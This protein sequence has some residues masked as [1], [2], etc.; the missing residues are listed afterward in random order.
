[1]SY[2]RVLVPLNG[3]DDA[4]A[5]LW[6]A[7]ETATRFDGQVIGLHAGLDSAQSVPYLGESVSAA[8]AD[9]M[10]AAMEGAA[11]R[12]RE[13]ANRAFVEAKTKYPGTD[14]EFQ[15][16]KGAEDAV[17]GSRGRLADLVVVPRP[18]D[19]MAMS[20]SH[21]MQAAILQCGRPVLIA[22]PSEQGSFA[23][24]ILVA[25]NGSAQAARALTAALPY[26]QKAGAVT[27]LQIQEGGESTVE[28][29][30]DY[31]AVHNCR[32]Q[33]ISQPRT[34]AIGDALLKAAFNQG[35]DLLVMGAYTHSRVRELIF[36]GATLDALLD[37]TIPV[38][39]AH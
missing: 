29:A 6:L 37:A 24:N 30:V 20:E 13:N 8:L 38:L 23:N 21:T 3:E 10:I 17:L 12:Q 15:W 28:D 31:L 11:A 14:G 1:M 39:M 25:W 22:P 19:E 2:K 9:N 33:G 5:A 7:F 18:V 36:G 35:A 34:E 32:A 4:R 16:V 27:L 26:L